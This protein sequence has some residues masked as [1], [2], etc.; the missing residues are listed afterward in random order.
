MV[1]GRSQ[2]YILRALGDGTEMQHSVEGRVPYL[3][4][5]ICR[6]SQLLKSSELIAEGTGKAALR[7]ALEG[8]VPEPARAR[9]KRPLV[10]PPLF[11]DSEGKLEERVREILFDGAPEFIDRDLLE[12]KT[13][14][15]DGACQSE[16]R[17][18]EPALFMAYCAAALQNRFNPSWSWT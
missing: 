8:I 18:A 1:R 6:L 4:S 7:R 9:P 12:E 14:A 16:H 5:D 3:D 13:T 10:A 2:G 15:L 17:R 11:W